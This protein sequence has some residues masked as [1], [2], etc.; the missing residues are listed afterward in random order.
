M[1]TRVF[2]SY[3]HDSNSHID[4]VLA[5]A[6]QLRNEGL[7]VALDQYVA[8]ARGLRAGRSANSG[9]RLR[10]LHLHA[11]LPTPLRRARIEGV[12]LAA[13]GEGSLALQL[14]HDAGTLNSRFIPVLFEEGAVDDIPLLPLRSATRY[15]LLTGYEDL[16]RRLTGQPSTPAR[17]IGAIRSMP[18]RS[19]SI[20]PP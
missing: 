10:P 13:T 20:S 18:P 3:S 4:C 9:G 2:I 1:A 11:Y 17:P 7:D 14:L 16:Y 12:G 6:D 15:R 19:R 5:L 8:A